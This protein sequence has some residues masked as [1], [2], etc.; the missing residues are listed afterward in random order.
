MPAFAGL[1]FPELQDLHVL[2]QEDTSKSAHVLGAGD[3][4]RRAGKLGLVEIQKRV[5]V[6]CAKR[7]AVKDQE[8]F[9]L[10]E[11]PGVLK[12]AAGPPRDRIPSKIRT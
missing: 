9:A 10:D 3:N 2:I 11:I 5:E 1:F 4:H 6:D 8:R 7:I 12:R